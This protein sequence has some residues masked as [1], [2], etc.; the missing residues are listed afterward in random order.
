LSTD[1]DEKETTLR[2]PL[3]ILIAVGT[4]ITV[5][6]S[7]ALIHGLTA[8]AVAASIAGPALAFL[9]PEDRWDDG[10]VPIRAYR[11]ISGAAGVLT[12]SL[13]SLILLGHFYAELSAASAALLFLSLAATAAPLPAVVRRGP[14][15]RQLTVRSAACLV[16]LGIAIVN[17]GT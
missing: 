16:P 1:V 11:G 9:L 8:A 13:G 3:L 14:V 7:G 17:S 5:T 12:F 15:W 2:V 6:Q 4:A 10:A